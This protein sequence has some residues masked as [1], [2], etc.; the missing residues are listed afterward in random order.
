VFLRLPPSAVAK[1]AKTAK[2]DARTAQIEKILEL[3]RNGMSLEK[4]AISVFGDAKK[5][6]NVQAI[7]NKF[8]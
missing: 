2:L 4:I 7:V 8:K 3:K 1:T 6:T 5:K